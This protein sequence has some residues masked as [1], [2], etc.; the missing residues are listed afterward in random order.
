[1]TEVMRRPFFG[2]LYA[3]S[4]DKDKMMELQRLL[5]SY[6]GR[7][8]TIEAGE[9]K[10]YTLDSEGNRIP[11]QAELDGEPE[12]QAKNQNRNRRIT[13]LSVWNWIKKYIP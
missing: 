3:Y 10:I 8:I 5:S 7:G 11:G 1:M 6:M 12:K 2:P 13:C 9:E 4:A